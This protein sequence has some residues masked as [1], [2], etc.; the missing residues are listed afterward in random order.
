MFLLL[1]KG[2]ANNGC[3]RLLDKYQIKYD[4]LNIDEITTC[5]YEYIVKSPGISLLDPIFR[6]LKGKIISDIELGYIITH[7]NIIGVTG[8][9]GKT[10]VVSMLGYILKE[11]Y[12]V[13]V[14]GNIGY[15][16][17]DALVDNPNCDYYIV[18]MSS[19]QLEATYKL[20]CIISVILNIS[21][22]HLDHH[23][24]FNDYI[25]SKIK[26][27]SNQ[28]YKN[29][30]IYNMD[31]PYLNEI[32][33]K[34]VSNTIGFSYKSSVSKIYV[35]NEYIYYQ[36]KRIFKIN[37]NEINYKHKIENYLAVLTTI[38]CL[39]FNLKKA[40]K[41]LKRFK[42]VKYRLNKIDKY[43]YNDAKS[44]NCGST[45]AA[46]NSLDKIHL[47]CGG[48][49]RGIKINLELKSLQKIRYV[50]SYG[51]TKNEIKKYFD[52][53]GIKCFSFNTLKDALR[54]AYIKR[55]DDEVILYSPMFASFDQYQSYTQRGEEFNMLYNKL[56]NKTS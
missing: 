33:K 41:L 19:F 44:T 54:S 14:C 16:F 36:N 11:R 34:C 21:M 17:C 39:D 24:A 20:D 4:Y 31:D 12:E 25:N 23:K 9:N 26:I 27:A 32:R 28:S 52:S 6:K 40:C 55:F 53:Y 5:D 38:T 48:Y 45:M 2:V 42:D 18:E 15:S 37:K 30:T 49:N 7:P 56:K 50:Y 3:K 1:G 13:C 10:S 22:C 8:S 29:F 51:E 47:I 35:L 43:I 46:I